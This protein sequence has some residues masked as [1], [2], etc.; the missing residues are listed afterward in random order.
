MVVLLELIPD[1]GLLLYFDSEQ[2]YLPTREVAE[3]Y[4][5]TS[6]SKHKIFETTVC[7]TKVSLCVG[8][9]G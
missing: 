4:L 2:T 9:L 3:P 8:I 7:M 5:A 6:S 1:D